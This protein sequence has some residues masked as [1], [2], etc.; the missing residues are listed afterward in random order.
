VSQTNKT[1]IIL[2]LLYSCKSK[3]ST[4]YPDGLSYYIRRLHNLPPHFS[5]VSTLPDITQK[6]TKKLCLPLNTVSGFVKNQFCCLKWIWQELVVWLGTVG[7]RSNVP[8]TLHMHAAMFATG[9]WL[10]RW[11]PEEYGPKYQWASASSRQCRVLV[12]VKCQVVQKH[13]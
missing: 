1:R 13:N 12:F 4:W 2:N 10:L 9:P 8:L 7:V 11:C 6:K 5:Y 3:F